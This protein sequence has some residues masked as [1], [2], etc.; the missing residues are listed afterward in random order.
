MRTVQLY[1]GG[2][3]LDLFKDES[4]S[5]TSSIQNISDISKVFTDFSQ[6]F[7]I[8]VSKINNSV[9][10][11]WY[12]NDLDSG[13]IAKKRV[14]ARLEINNT[15]FRIG[16]V[17][18]EGADI[19][20]NRPENYKITFFGD[21]VT[22]K[23]NFGDDKLSDLVYTSLNASSAP[24]DVKA[25]IESTADLDVRFPLITS[26]RA[27]TYGDGGANDVS[28]T[29]TPIS[30]SELFP[31]V[32]ASKIL[33]F[34]ENK[35]SLSFSGL[36]LTNKR[37]T[38]LFTWFKNSKEPTF[39]LEPLQVTFDNGISDYFVD[40]RV[41][42]NHLQE[43]IVPEPSGYSYIPYT[44]GNSYGSNSY[45]SFIFYHKCDLT[46]AN[47]YVDFIKHNTTYPSSTPVVQTFTFNN[48]TTGILNSCSIQLPN[49]NYSNFNYSIQI[50]CAEAITIYDTDI[51]H[52]FTVSFKNNITHPT[53][54]YLPIYITESIDT[55]LGTANMGEPYTSNTNMDIQSLAPDIKVSDYFT[56]ILNAFNLTC[57]P[58]QDGTFQIEPLQDWYA[59]GNTVDITPHVI[60]DS[61]TITRPKLHKSIS[62][63][64]EKSNSMLNVEF[65]SN[66]D[67]QYGS[68][69]SQFDFDGSPLKIKLPF[70]NPM[71]S[72]FTGT[73]LQIAYGITDAVGGADKSYIPKCTN[74]YLYED[75]ACN[76]KFNDGTTT[77]TITNYMPFGQDLEYND[78][79]YSSNFGSDISTLLLTDTENSLY[80]VY[81]RNYLE[82]LFNNK[83]RKVA[84]STI[85][86]L[87]MLANL[88][89]DAAIVIRD[90][91]YRIDSMKTN[92]TTGKV[93]LVLLTDLTLINLSGAGG[94]T[95]KPTLPIT[96]INSGG[97]TIYVPVRPIKDPINTSPF[98]GGGTYVKVLATLE[99]QFINTNPVIPVTFY[100]PTTLSIT[101]PPNTTGATRT[102]T[103][104]LEYYN[105]DDTLNST[106]YIYIIQDY[107]HSFLL[108]ED[109]GYILQEN[110]D[111]IEI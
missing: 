70:E 110:Y 35:Y 91:R 53:T 88:T 105:A 3:K 67:R 65:N 97:G 95:V 51:K 103:I 18:L 71:F 27:W 4:I 111:K 28:E 42:L 69:S 8:P 16:K 64:Y 41:L 73:N 17:Q 26:N 48:S 75:T 87:S 9:F 54:G 94:S 20:N 22:I 81:Y 37:F 74:L 99:T 66:F 36:F 43:S 98:G 68:L 86:P 10:L 6:T 21:V 29:A 76:F 39:L 60:D 83:T 96:P 109:G 38:N 72:K 23:D 55:F 101:V 79:N 40:N 1:I 5:V 32:R 63:E 89:L 85:M 106:D 30:Y 59:Y 45:K 90:K 93:D 31:A 12:N 49:D 34:I 57:F 56:G 77:T 107:A 58:L 82:N 47:Y 13:F 104:P 108:K 11:H 62:F 19:K 14:A 50:R 92:L 80:N 33:E 25:S 44:N 78:V 61:I 100:S 52:T 15:P 102:N 46:N 24:S 2:V 7:S 84:V